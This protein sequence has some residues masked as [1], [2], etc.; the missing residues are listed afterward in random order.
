MAFTLAC[1]ITVGGLV[2]Q[3]ANSVEIVSS[4]KTLGDTC[5]VKIPSR[6]VL[7]AGSKIE[8]VSF[9][10]YFKV[11]DPIKVELGYNSTLNT[12][13][14]GYLAKILPRQ[15]FELVAEDAIYQLKRSDSI[16]KSYKTVKLRALLAELV[17]G[18]T[19]DSGMPD[20]VIENFLIERAT[21]AQVL[22]ELKEK[23][24]LAVYFRAGKLHAGLAYFEKVAVK[25]K[26]HLQ[27]NVVSDDLQ[28]Q[29]DT[30]VRMKVKVILMGSD[31]GKYS[32]EIGDQDGEV[33]TLHYQYR[34]ALR[35]KTQALENDLKKQYTPLAQND[36]KKFKFTGYRG[37]LTAFGLPYVVHSQSV[38]VEDG[39]YSERKG[40]YLV[41]EV[42]TTWGTGGFRRQITLGPKV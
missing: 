38:E 6:G 27:K 23:Y 2:L 30:D 31:N 39:R 40:S 17:P 13:F 3:S 14:E 16:T 25:S 34:G 1:R 41:D 26:F 22:L 42:R 28:Y 33:R 35:K 18:V 7:R 37:S 8:K 32:F 12:E 19:L 4:W 21:K 9:G 5:T 15:P 29:T 24:G 20:I 10:E 36:L 11:G